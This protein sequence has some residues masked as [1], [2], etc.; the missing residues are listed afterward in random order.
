MTIVE[1]VLHARRV[2][3]KYGDVVGGCNGSCFVAGEWYPDELLAR[4]L[5]RRVRV[6][7]NETVVVV[8]VVVAVVVDVVV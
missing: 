3:V 4:V 6:E 2:S 7:K 8:C 5:R 1:T